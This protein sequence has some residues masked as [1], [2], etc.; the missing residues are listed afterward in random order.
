MTKIPQSTKINIQLF[1]EKLADN[2]K[3][4]VKQRNNLKNQI[5]KIIITNELSP[6]SINIQEGKTVKAILILEVQLKEQTLDYKLLELISKQNQM[7]M[8]FLVKFEDK[9]QLALYY[10]KIYT[11][12]WQY[13]KQLDLSI[14]G[15][16]L[17]ETWE[18][19]V[20]QI[21]LAKDIPYKDENIPLEQKIQN[22]E[23][24]QI[25][26]KQIQNLEQQARKETQ[27][28]KK[29]ELVGEIGKLKM[30]MEEIK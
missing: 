11:T 9:A 14:T 27:P 25:I 24:Y 4:P 20:K 10:N 23:K 21:A 15:M 28:K 30:K 17:D 16:N 19:I 1:K 6:K 22:Q 13:E 7:K 12:P 5:K 26:Q 2:L 8:I 29:F 3:L 18:N